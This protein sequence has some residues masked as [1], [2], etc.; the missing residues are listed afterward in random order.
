MH[1]TVGL[2]TFPLHFIFLFFF[3]FYKGEKCF[4]LQATYSTKVDQCCDLLALLYLSPN[5]WYANT[6][7]D[8]WRTLNCM[9]GKPYSQEIPDQVSLTCIS[10]SNFQTTSAETTN[11]W[12]WLMPSGSKHTCS[13]YQHDCTSSW[14]MHAG[15]NM[16]ACSHDN[17]ISTFF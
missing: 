2:F 13:L 1:K 4:W 7:N 14:A 3:H 8:C 11:P 10:L 12:F 9:W 6:L 15:I 17:K 16:M 5:G